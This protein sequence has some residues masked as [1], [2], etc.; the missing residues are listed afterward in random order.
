MVW[1]YRRYEIRG[2]FFWILLQT[3]SH[4]TSNHAVWCWSVF[5]ACELVVTAKKPCAF[6]CSKHAQPTNQ[7]K[8]ALGMFVCY[9]AKSQY[10]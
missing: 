9:F 10:W 1:L 2:F 4:M 6:C 7:S 8:Y 3:L 5:G